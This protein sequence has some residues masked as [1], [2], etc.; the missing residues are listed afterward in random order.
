MVAALRALFTFIIRNFATVSV[1]WAIGDIFE[2]IFQ[3]RPKRTEAQKGQV[4]QKILF[5]AGAIAVVVGIVQLIF[6][7]FTD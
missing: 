2:G 3:G 7:R 4:T 1:G 6:K 5:G